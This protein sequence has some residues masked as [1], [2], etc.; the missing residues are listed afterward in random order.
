MENNHKIYGDVVGVPI[1]PIDSYTKDEMNKLLANKVNKEDIVSAYKFCGSV[2]KFEDL[3]HRYD[4]ILDGTPKT[5]EGE[6]LSPD[7]YTYD[8]QTNSLTVNRNAGQIFIPIKSTLLKAGHYAT[9][10]KPEYINTDFVVLLD[11]E[12]KVFGIQSASPNTG[13]T[14][15]SSMYIRYILADATQGIKIE[16]GYVETIYKTSPDMFY[17]EMDGTYEGVELFNGEL[18]NGNVYN[19]LLDGMNYAWTGTKWD[20]LGGE[21]KDLEAR[22]DIENLEIQVGDIE[23]ALDS[24][25][26]IQNSLIGGEAE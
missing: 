14:L 10:A 21:H 11:K 26:E 16:N 3:P 17:T 2:D 4:L 6:D 24:I 1:P 13:S 8:E 15:S 25:I 23:T 12:N 19:V 9:N 5:H 20:A 22:A 18:E 7:L